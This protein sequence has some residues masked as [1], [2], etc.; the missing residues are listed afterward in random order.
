MWVSIRH[1]FANV[2]ARVWLA[3]S[4]QSWRRLPRPSGSAS[5]SAEGPEPQRILLLGSSI[6]VG[7]GVMTHD[8]GFAGHLARRLSALTGRGIVIDVVA[9]PY[10]DHRRTIAT[11]ESTDLARYHAIILTLGGMEALTFLPMRTWRRQL[12]VVLDLIEAR[13]PRTLTVFPLGIL[14]APSIARIHRTLRTAMQAH[15]TR[16][17][18]AA[19]ELCA[20][21]PRTVFVDFAPEPVGDL[22]IMLSRSTY[23]DWSALIAPAIASANRSAAPS[24]VRKNSEGSVSSSSMSTGKP[25]RSRMRST[26]A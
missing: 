23:A 18:L 9:S 17:N 19:S 13:A 4:D 14:P 21:R 10:L 15:V 3:T 24:E 11:L 7:Y 2:V 1:A 8:I 20:Q 12:S 5:V 26:R 6:A 16:L 25:S 22:G